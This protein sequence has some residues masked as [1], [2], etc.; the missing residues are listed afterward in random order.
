M[1]EVV[2]NQTALN[3]LAEAWTNA[4]SLMRQDITRAA[5]EIDLRLQSDPR[6]QGESRA[7]G[8]RILFRAPLGVAF[9]VDSTRP[10][11]AC[12]SRGDSKFGAVLEPARSSTT[13][14]LI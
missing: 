7:S 6:N 13:R 9:E 10:W 12:C 5:Q 1:F 14:F 8:Q 4:D 2:W 11:F 3:K